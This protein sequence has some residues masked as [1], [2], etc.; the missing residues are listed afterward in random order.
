LSNSASVVAESYTTGFGIGAGAQADT[1]VRHGTITLVLENS[2]SN[3]W[4]ANGT[5]ARSDGASSSTCGGSK[6]LSAE[7]TQLRITTD[8][9]DTFDAGEINIL[10]K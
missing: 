5:L 1:Q 3:T 6:S 10:Y 8:G 9:A 2:S 4:I 7:L